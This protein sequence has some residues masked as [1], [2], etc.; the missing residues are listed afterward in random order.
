MDAAS[1]PFKIADKL[2][3]RIERSVSMSIILNI[4]N[5]LAVELEFAG[6]KMDRMASVRIH[7]PGELNTQT[8]QGMI[9]TRRRNRPGMENKDVADREPLFQ[10]EIQR[11]RD[12]LRLTAQSCH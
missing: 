12:N 2:V 4:I 7:M 11:K 6:V 5:G 10:K 3:D 1:P 8:L 9:E